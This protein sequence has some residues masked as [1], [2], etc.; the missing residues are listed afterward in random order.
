LGTRRAAIGTLLETTL[1]GNSFSS[2]ATSNAKSPGKRRDMHRARRRRGARLQAEGKPLVESDHLSFTEESV[3]DCDSFTILI[4]GEL[5][6]TIKLFTDNNGTRDK[7]VETRQETE[8]F[9]NSV[10]RKEIATP[11]HNT[12]LIDPETR[13][14]ANMGIIFKVT[15]PG[16]GAV[17]CD[18]SSS[19]MPASRSHA[20]D[21]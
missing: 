12:V 11:F 20:A 15:V 19:R 13:L 10:T 3:W 5:D 16:A 4:K 8:I 14:G 18:K 6:F 1:P 17:F 9:I 21:L 7:G 2:A